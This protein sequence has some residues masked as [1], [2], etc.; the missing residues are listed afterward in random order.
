MKI[1]KNLF[2]QRKHVIGF[3]GTKTLG[4]TTLSSSLKGTPQTGGSV[5]IKTEHAFEEKEETRNSQSQMSHKFRPRRFL[6][7]VIWVTDAYCK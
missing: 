6:A 4:S 3:Q 2:H 1:C 7:K 5:V